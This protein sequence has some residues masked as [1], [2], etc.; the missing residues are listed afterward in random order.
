MK[1]FTEIVED[2]QLIS[3]ARESGG[4]DYYIEGVFLQAEITNKN[5]RRYP[6]QVLADEVKRYVTEVVNKNRAFG[7]LGHPSGPSINLDRVSHIITELRKDGTDFIGR[8][9][10]SKTPMGEIARGIME[11]G[12]QLGVSS[13]AMG[14]L[15]E[16]KGVMVVQSDLRLSTAADIVAD[17]SAPD[18]F[19][20]GIM[21]GVEWVYDPVKN[22]WLEEKLNDTKKKIHNMSKSK[23]EEQKM[24][25]FE[26][27]IASLALKN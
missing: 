15:K 13:R 20:K 24:A 26:N 7:E 12:G 11:S 21:E 22:T 1:L 19:V 14:S 10:L 8:A 2:I 17:P 18:A 6:E 16:E 25:I 23:L 9:K 5:G 3:E 4:K 27:Y